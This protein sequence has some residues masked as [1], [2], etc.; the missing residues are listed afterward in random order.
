MS[1]DGEAVHYSKDAAAY[2]VLGAVGH[3][4]GFISCAKYP[5]EL[6]EV[7]GKYIS[8]WNDTPG[9]T[10]EEVLDALEKASRIYDAKHSRA[11]SG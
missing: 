6:V 4:K 11:V 7:V 9:R 2:C 1:Y 8:I 3:V 5:P 10:K